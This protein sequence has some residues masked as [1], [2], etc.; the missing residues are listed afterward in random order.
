MLSHA[1]L[2]FYRS[3]TAL[4]LGVSLLA[5]VSGP[6]GHAAATASAVAE[7]GLPSKVTVKDPKDPKAD[8]DIRKVAMYSENEDHELAALNFTFAEGPSTDDGFAVLWN[9]DADAKPDMLMYTL[10]QS[11]VV[12]KVK[13]WGKGGKDISGKGCVGYYGADGGDPKKVTILFD[14]ECLGES[15]RFQIN[16]FTYDQIDGLGNA[17]YLPADKTWTKAV[18]SV[19]PFPGN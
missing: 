3:K 7:R 19:I 11:V 14:P 2:T 10:G 6:T 17:D 18:D 13:D 9:L 5:L 4:A 12:E 15:S 1:R 8:W 16:A